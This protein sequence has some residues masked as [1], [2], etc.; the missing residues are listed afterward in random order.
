M[1]AV[2]VP[3]FDLPSASYSPYTAGLECERKKQFKD[4]FT[5][6]AVQAAGVSRVA[7]IWAQYSAAFLFTVHSQVGAGPDHQG[8]S[9][10]GLNCAYNKK[11][12]AG[13]ISGLKVNIAILLFFAK[14]LP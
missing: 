11:S 7:E 13:E 1:E 8:L 5:S 14:V 3:E 9:G 10:S 2:Q 12:T 4:S 6:C